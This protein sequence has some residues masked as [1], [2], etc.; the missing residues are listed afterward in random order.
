MVD[1]RREGIQCKECG[2]TQ[3]VIEITGPGRIESIKFT[4]DE[5]DVTTKFG[6]AT[7]AGGVPVKMSPGQ[8]ALPLEIQKSTEK[9]PVDEPIPVRRGRRRTA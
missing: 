1:K 2:K 4:C 6:R 9:E 3:A 5:C 8:Q 7:R